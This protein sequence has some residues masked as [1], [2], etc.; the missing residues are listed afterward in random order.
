[1]KCIKYIK[2]PIYSDEYPTES[3]KG[4]KPGVHFGKKKKSDNM[5]PSYTENN[6]LCI[7]SVTCTKPIT[8]NF[9]MNKTD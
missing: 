5:Y 3:Q 1:M 4:G 6:P 7:L 2:F 9:C 8:V